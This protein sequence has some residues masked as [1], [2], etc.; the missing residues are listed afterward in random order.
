MNSNDRITMKLLDELEGEMDNHDGRQYAE[1]KNP[2]V[3]T[4]E[5][6]PAQN[7]DGEGNQLDKPKTDKTNTNRTYM[8]PAREKM[9]RESEEQ[10]A[11]KMP[12]R[13]QFG[14]SKRGYV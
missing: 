12:V 13:G 14:R 3:K 1:A 7:P 11:R 9:L 4:V 5:M 8:D 2:K 6:V 10:S